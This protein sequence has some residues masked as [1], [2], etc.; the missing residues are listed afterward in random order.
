MVGPS[1]VDLAEQ[2]CYCLA[3][4]L[5]GF[6]TDCQ[7]MVWMRCLSSTRSSGDHKQARDVSRRGMI[8]MGKKKMIK[9]G[10]LYVRE[11]GSLAYI[12]ITQ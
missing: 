2:I 8:R 4:E 10:T 7:A 6:V 11:K 1:L 9:K 3:P 5:D 12:G